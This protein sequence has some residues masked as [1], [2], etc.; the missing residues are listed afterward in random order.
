MDHMTQQN[1]ALV[2][3]MAA[4]ANSLQSQAQAL[5]Q[6]VAVF[7]LADGDGGQRLGGGAPRASSYGN[8][9]KPALRPISNTKKPSLGNKPKSLAAPAKTAA[10]AAPAAPAAD[11][12]ESF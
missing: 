2:E 3:E 7:K 10:P 9:T 6:T 5:V 4:A 11:E 8:G 12:W 1:A